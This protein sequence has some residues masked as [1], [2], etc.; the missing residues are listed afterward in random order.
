M[1]TFT[2]EQRDIILDALDH[3]VQHLKA[4]GYTCWQTRTSGGNEMY[5]H[6]QHKVMAVNA[7]S[8]L[9]MDAKTVEPEVGP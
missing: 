1:T 5:T 6:M 8:L 7:T 2:A 3:Y 4:A 9:V